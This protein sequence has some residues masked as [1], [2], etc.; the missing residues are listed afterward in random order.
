MGKGDF[1]YQA[2]EEEFNKKQDE[3]Y[4]KKMAELEEEFPLQE[5]ILK[6]EQMKANE[7]TNKAMA[8]LAKD[9]A[10]DPSLP[11]IKERLSE[12]SDENVFRVDSGFPGIDKILKGFRGA[13]TYLVAGL[14]KS[15]KS[16]FLMNILDHLLIGGVKVGY[17]NTELTD[18]E[19]FDRMAAISNK[20][21][22]A[23][24]EAN[25]EYRKKWAEIFH[26]SFFYAGIKNAS[27]LKKD[28]VLSFEKTLERL[29]EFVLDGVKVAMIDDLTTFNT[30]ATDKKA[31]WVVLASCISQIVTFAKAKEII[32]F[33]VV[34]TKPNVVF[35]ETPQGIKKWVES[36]PT[37]IFQD[38]VIVTK[39]PSLSDVYG[40]GSA[41]SQLSGA[42]L[43]WRP[44][45]K[46]NSEDYK[47]LSLIILDSFRHAPSGKEVLMIFKGEKSLFSELEGYDPETKD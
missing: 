11:S 21:T 35:G 23:E 12:E 15:G 24:T 47:E 41:L 45:Q 33:I 30:L 20:I 13:N 16:S 1:D 10:N 19:F 2:F 7:R 31:G 39:K 32:I 28:N 22:T 42:I 8:E 40:G 5:R 36:D 4:A 44:Y 9:I 37:K 43:I 17:V 29:Q 26:S 38:S 34:H 27:D 25:P 6:M 14:E 18:T 3:K 46:F